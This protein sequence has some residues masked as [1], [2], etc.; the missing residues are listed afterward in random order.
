MDGVAVVVVI[1]S[2]V[3]GDRFEFMMSFMFTGSGGLPTG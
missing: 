3:E 1:I 2:R